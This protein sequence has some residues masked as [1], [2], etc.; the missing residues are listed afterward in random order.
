MYCTKSFSKTKKKSCVFSETVGMLAD[1]QPGHR[2]EGQR[3][4][5]DF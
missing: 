3:N 1:R 5:M 4:Q 2:D